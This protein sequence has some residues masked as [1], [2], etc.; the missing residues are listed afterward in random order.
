MLMLLGAG[1]VWAAP[2]WSAF[3]DKN[4][5]K[6]GLLK[7]H[8]GLY[9]GPVGDG[10]GVCPGPGPKAWGL[11]EGRAFIPASVTKLF[12]SGAALEL[13]GAEERFVTQVRA[14]PVAPS[15]ARD[16]YLVGGG[17][18]SFVSE[19]MWLLVQELLRW[20]PLEVEDIVVDDSLFR[21]SRDRSGRGL[22]SLQRAY[23]APVGAMNFNWSV[24]NVRLGPGEQ[25]GDKARIRL[26][27][28]DGLLTV[29]NKALTVRRAARAQTKIQVIPGT[30]KNGRCIGA[31]ELHVSGQVAL[32]S[33]ERLWYRS[34]VGDPACWSAWN[35]KAFLEE[36]GVAVRS[37]LRV[38]EAPQ[39]ARLLA[40]HKSLALKDILKGFMRF[41][42]NAMAE[43]L[44]SHLGLKVQ[45][46]PGA[47]LRVLTDYI[48]SKGLKDFQVHSASGL[49][50]KNRF[51]PADVGEFLSKMGQHLRLGVE[52]R[53]A[54]AVGGGEGSLSGRMPDVSSLVRA[55]TGM[56]SGV[57][58]L[59]GYVRT[60]CSGAERVFAFFYNGPKT[61]S[62]RA[63]MD[64]LIKE[65]TR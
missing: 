34:I 58:S 59:A 14:G 31:G 53:S 44:V 24:V 57:A 27:P 9:L 42:N 28:M 19:S 43:M 13:L 7:Q 26:D 3:L 17:D 30:Q 55:K 38:G 37:G 45:K 10:G 60:P 6:H 15:G 21:W 63:F 48:K 11:N 64:N 52:F 8:L 1:P 41:S 61:N 18:P 22:A 36:R 23:N 5:K 4:L 49:S 20:G 25:V 56:L 65:L 33:K 12:V 54:L 62:A 46:Q 50:R 39:G 29:R 40:S 16:L 51:R 2:E 32:G 35:F 47:G